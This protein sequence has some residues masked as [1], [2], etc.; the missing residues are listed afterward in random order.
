MSNSSPVEMLR[1]ADGQLAYYMEQKQTVREQVLKALQWL[2]TGLAAQGWKNVK[3][4]ESLVD[5]VIDEFYLLT[6]GGSL[7]AFSLAEIWFMQGLVV[8]EEFV[9]PI[10]DNPAPIK[11]VVEALEAA[12]AAANCTLVSLGTRANPRQDGLARIFEHAGC[13]RATTGFVKE[14]PNG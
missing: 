2:D 7:V 9:A 8:E 3:S 13:K 14:I 12:G 1:Y 6:V 4:P 5:L 11:L 10:T